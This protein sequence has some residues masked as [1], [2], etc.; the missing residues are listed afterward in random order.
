MELYEQ[1]QAK[2]EE[3]RR[4]YDT[5]NMLA[6]ELGLVGK[7]V[8]LL[9][10]VKAQFHD[11]TKSAEGRVAL[12]SSLQVSGTCQRDRGGVGG[13]GARLVSSFL[14]HKRALPSVPTWT[15]RLCFRL[16]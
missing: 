6:T 5:H 11:A 13:G 15:V 8:S 14:S 10:S 9:N 16:R 12:A 7:E 3:T 1:V 4:H 2:L